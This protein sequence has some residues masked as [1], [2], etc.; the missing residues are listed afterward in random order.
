MNKLIT[1]LI[2]TS[3]IV[4]G[5]VLGNK[6]QNTNTNT[7]QGGVKA[8]PSGEGPAADATKKNNEIVSEGI[9]T[10]SDIPGWKTYSNKE[11]GFEI[12]YPK[13]YITKSIDGGVYLEHPTYNLAPTVMVE[14]GALSVLVTESEVDELVQEIENVDPPL[15]KVVSRKDYV[16]AGVKGVEIIGNFAS[17]VEVYYLFIVY[18]KK[19]YLIKYNAVGLSSVEKIVSTFRFIN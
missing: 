2:L 15:S 8:Y 5:C 1:I 6:N 3:L 11:Y 19:N 18:N 16:L 10:D 13:D 7:N 14:G 17:G 9:I 12:S 4:S